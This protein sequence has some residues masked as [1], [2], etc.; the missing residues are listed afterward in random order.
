MCLLGSRARNEDD[1]GP[2][3]VVLDGRRGVL[4][5]CRATHPA[6]VTLICLPLEACSSYFLGLTAL[7]TPSSSLV[8]RGYGPCRE[9]ARIH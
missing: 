1:S 5:A 8:R 7:I 2:R 3:T 6:G 9:G 4:W